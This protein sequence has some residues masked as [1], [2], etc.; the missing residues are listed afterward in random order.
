M[1]KFLLPALFALVIGATS[2][3][4]DFDV[5]APYKDI[6]FVYGMLNMYDSAHY[7]RI[8]KAYLQENGDAIALAE[9]SDSNFYKNL[10]VSFVE[11]NQN[12]GAITRTL[13]LQRVDLNNEGFPKQGGTFFN[14][15]NWGYKIQKPASGYNFS[16]YYNYRLIIKNIET[17]RLDSSKLF[18]FVSGDSANA[19]ER[20][21]IAQFDN[22][23]YQISFPRMALP[24]FTFELTGRAPRN[25][26]MVEGHIIFH[27]AD[28]NIVTGAYQDKIAD[29][30]F[31]TDVVEAEGTQFSLKT[32]NSAIYNF[33]RSEIGDA[34]ENTVRLLDSC[35]VRIF[36]GSNELYQYQQV[37][38]SQANGLT[39]DQI[40][41]SYTNMTGGNALGIIATRATRTFVGAAI[42]NA[43]LDSIKKNPVLQTL[44]IR[45]RSSR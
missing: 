11:S 36:A 14:T 15:P 28:S 18:T 41:P 29:F 31:G 43:T 21:Y 37:S 19:A 22:V 25:C 32:E 24:T 12:S 33:L 10:E 20:F 1:K 38:L 39:G 30:T 8:Q 4:D 13:N 45:G 17:G 7:V 35:D 44:N 42:D 2:C 27:Y 26:K 34:P 6:T 9:Q 23:N 5:V 3:S 16:A 40:K